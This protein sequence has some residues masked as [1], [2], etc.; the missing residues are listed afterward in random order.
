VRR[1]EAG[2]GGDD[3]HAAAVGDGARQGFDFS[4]GFD[5]AQAVAQPLHGRAGDEDAAFE[6]VLQRL[7]AEL[8]GDRGQQAVRRA[9]RRAAGVH[10]HERAGA[11]RV[12]GLPRARA[13]LA[14]ERGLLIAG[15][16]HDRNAV[17]G[18]GE[19]A[20]R[21]SH[22]GQDAA[23]HAEEL[24]QLVIPRGAMDVEKHGARGV[25][26]VGDVC[27]S[28]GQIP[29]EPG[30]DGAEGEIARL[31]AIEQPFDL[32]ARKVGV[33]DEAGALADQFRMRRERLAH[34]SGAAV[35]PDDGIGD[36]LSGLA[37]PDHGGLALV[38]DADG[39]NG[40]VGFGDGLARDLAL[41]PPDFLG[42]VLDP[43]GLRIELAELALGDGEDASVVG[44]DEGA[45]A[46][47]AGVEGENGRHAGNSL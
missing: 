37:I 27:F 12:L 31:A 3:G 44:E 34:G 16:A 25:G 33:D 40:D 11:V 13:A 39:A 17:G 18:L 30:V 7:V 45:R 47:R 14:E 43:A 4:R 23:R 9:D 8:P 15:D 1:A 41:R 26:D 20:A 28:A 42:I 19:E 21:G 32:R 2:E 46:G 29:D 35:L 36:R 22:L 10:H 6:G 24:Q 38:G 5:D